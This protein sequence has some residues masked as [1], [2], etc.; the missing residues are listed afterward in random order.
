[1]MNWRNIWIGVLIIIAIGGVIWSTNNGKEQQSSNK[2]QRDE[3]SQQKMQAPDFSL[4]TMNGKTIELK[5]NN[6]KPTL[7]NFWAS[8]CPPCKVEMPHIQKAY[9]K[10]GDQVNFLMVNVTAMDEVTK[11]KK[12]LKDGN[13]SFPVLL[14][15]TGEVSE[16]Y[17]AFGLP[18]TY[19]IDQNAV[20]VDHIVGPMS[21]D[22]LT[23]IMEQISK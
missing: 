9:E 4:Q 17:Q 21:E 1:M 11:V 8:W 16:T 14:D 7:I 2:H 6:G 19:I 5:K 18:T 3:G 10:Y 12:F 15:Q 13:Y 22:Q 20:I 23:E